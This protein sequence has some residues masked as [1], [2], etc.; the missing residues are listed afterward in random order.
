MDGHLKLNCDAI[1]Y[2]GDS[3]ATWGVAVQDQSRD[4]ITVRAGKTDGIHDVFGAE[5]QAMIHAVQIAVELGA[6]RVIMETDSELLAIALNRRGPDFSQLAASLDD[7]KIQLHSWFSHCKVQ[8]CRRSANN[9]VHE[10]AKLG[11]L[12]NNHEMA[13]WDGDVPADI[14]DLVMDELSK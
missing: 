6:I 14:V 8:A 10:L 5:L 9:V 11:N 3:H 7:L 4:L 13:S 2:P 12:C 1:F